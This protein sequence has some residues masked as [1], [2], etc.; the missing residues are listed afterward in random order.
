MFL[1]RP[2]ISA[3]SFKV[4]TLLSLSL[5]LGPLFCL[6]A[7]REWSDWSEA[8]RFD[9]ACRSLLN[10]VIIILWSF[11]L[12]IHLTGIQD[13]GQI[14]RLMGSVNTGFTNWTS[15][16]PLGLWSF[17]VKSEASAYSFFLGFSPRKSNVLLIFICSLDTR[18]PN[19]ILTGFFCCDCWLFLRCLHN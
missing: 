18:V 12:S 3:L 2:L 4:C 16:C 5:A 7:R 15:R 19:W 1:S 9:G 10:H 14:D 6:T 11:N 17:H 8:E 13:Y